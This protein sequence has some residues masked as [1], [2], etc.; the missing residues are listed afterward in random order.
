MVHCLSFKKFKYLFRS[1]LTSYVQRLWQS[2]NPIAGLLWPLSLIFSIVI[3]IRRKAFLHGY[4]KSWVSPTPLIIIGN[5][6]VGGTGKTPIVIALARALCRAGYAPG[7]ITRG[8][9]AAYTAAPQHVKPNDNA[10]I[11]GDEPLLMAQALADCNIPVYAYSCRVKA[12]QALLENYPQTN[13]LISDDGLQH[14]ALAR[15][16][17]RDLEIVVID[18]RLL[19]NHW[20]LPAGPLREPLTR[21]RDITLW[22]GNSPKQMAAHHFFIPFILRT[23]ARQ[24]CN[25][26]QQRSLSTFCALPAHSILASAGMGYPEK[27][28][29]SLRQ[30]HIQFIP[31]ALPDHF[32]FSYNPFSNHCVQYI[33]VTEKDAVKCQYFNDPRIWIVG[34]DA[35]LPSTFMQTVLHR[36][37][38]HH[39]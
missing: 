7:I 20:L 38:T 24:L 26:A 35:S 6:N 28:F 1:T 5:L 13:V 9:G 19:G 32:D 33:L 30:Q 27:F 37:E 18:T 29:A 25:P 21:R 3:K 11:V 14:Y 36:L 2:R 4:L 34:V 23:Q 16:Q 31:L 10:A 17:Q 22:T 15:S 12:A 8:Y 39:G